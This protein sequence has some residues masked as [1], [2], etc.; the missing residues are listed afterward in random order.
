VK[1]IV[2]DSACWSAALKHA[3][4]LLLLAVGLWLAGC[5]R[6]E[7]RPISAADSAAKL[8]GRTLEDAALKAFL[9]KGLKRELSEWP[10]TKWDFEM[11]TLA[12]LYYHPSLEVARAQWA[13]A[14]G[15]E[16]TAGQRPNP[17]LNVTPGYDTTKSALPPWI[18]LGYLDLPIETMGKRR[19][20]R[21]KAAEL[22]EAAKLNILTVAWQVR[23]EL[24]ASLVDFLGAG[25]R[26]A[27]LEKQ[28]LLQE[29]AVGLLEQR[30]KAGA[31]SSSEVMLERVALEKTRLDLADAERLR[32]EAQA[33]VAEAVGIPLGALQ[34][35]EVAS[36][37]PEPTAKA[38]ELISAELRRRALQSRP[39]ILTALA[40]YAAS[41]AALQLEIAKQYPD[42]HLS[43][44]YQYDQG[45]NKWSLGITFELPVLNQNQ[46][47]IAEAA[48]RRTE[49][50]ARFNALQ[51]KV[52]GQIERAVAVYQASEKNLSTLE[53][54]G[55]AQAK[56]RE[57]VAA[58][59]K[60]GAADQLDLAN[61]QIEFGAAELVRVDGRVKIQQ[62]M[63]ALE[64]A[65]Q[66]PVDLPE[67]NYQGETSDAR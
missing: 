40:E 56:Q 51:A 15:G 18:P 13:V 49:A 12:A 43:P 17:T 44:G 45:D 64:D 32:A 4:G 34:S 28:L 39:D 25:Q 54:L 30:L 3:L 26:A 41:Q 21:A 53:A 58:Q 48:A 16:K 47:P 61:A 11:L 10:A 27:L 31:I 14:Q 57:A 33:R 60:A 8:E 2:L 38:D 35:V 37:L 29:Q 46:G 67:V 42:V 59:L 7:P 24:R 9:E 20:R 5:A 19:Y 62:A 50:A 52:L 36:E 63:G 66:R 6:F 1:I 55:A 22:S 65:M 23:S